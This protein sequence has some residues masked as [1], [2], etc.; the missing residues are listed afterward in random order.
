MNVSKAFWTWVKCFLTERTQQAD[1]FIWYYRLQMPHAWLAFRMLR[2]L[3]N[4]IQYSTNTHNYADECTIKR[5]GVGES[6]N[7]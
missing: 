2:H 4:S 1:R 5:T 6:R 7:K 3:P